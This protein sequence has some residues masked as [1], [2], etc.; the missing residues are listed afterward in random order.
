MEPSAGTDGT[1]AHAPAGGEDALTLDALRA[2]IGDRYVLE[3]VLGRGGMGTVYLA[4]DRQ[5]DRPVAL[6]V[7]PREFATREELRERFL[8][9]TRL[10]AGFSHPNIVPVFAVED[11]EDLLAFAMAYVE[12]ESLDERVRRAGP[13]GVRDTVRLLQD[14]GYGLAYAHGRGVVHRDIKPE[15]IMLE[16]ATGR[17][18]LMDFGIARAISAAPATARGLTRVGEVV[19]TP[20]FMSPEQAS[21][22]QVDGRSDLYSLGLVAWFA[23]TGRLAITGETTQRILARQLTETLPPIATVRGDLPAPLAAAIDRLLA[24]DPAERFP[25][26]EALVEA[27][28]VAQLAPP[29]V[30]LAVRLF[31]QDGRNYLV[32]AVAV[33]AFAAAFVAQVG[34]AADLDRL[35]AISVAGALEFVLL[36]S[37]ARQART[38]RAQGFD[39]A[40]LR[41]G[42]AAIMAEGDDARAQARAVP[43]VARKRR[44]RQAAVPLVFLLGL[45]NLRGGLAKRAVD[46]AGV[47][48]LSRVSATLVITGLCAMVV[49]VVLLAIDPLR[50]PIVQR[51]ANAF[52]G[53]PPGAWL[54]GSRRAA[55]GRSGAAAPVPAAPVPVPPRAARG[56]DRLGDIERRLA[57][58]ERQLAER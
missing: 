15:N 7:L 5:L 21:G 27:I 49:S 47:V 36:M 2:Q 42:L 28:D 16:R 8:R 51:I 1:R 54:M 55:R 22:D 12:G 23:V 29:S 45:Y 26:A 53:G 37:I 44:I 30:P 33:L 14:V 58:V 9:E 48:H 39:H 24:K 31:Q 6:K 19:G 52:W 20:E 40:A 13:L 38:L 25:T 3:R 50:R 43:G 10:A 56:G 34:D 17:A 32:S 57:S 35:A 4:R 18:L 46:A 41:A 11:R